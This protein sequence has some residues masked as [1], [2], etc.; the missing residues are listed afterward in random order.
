MC[1]TPKLWGK[2]DCPVSMPKD[3]VIRDL[4]MKGTGIFILRFPNTKLQ[5]EATDICI[6]VQPIWGKGKVC[7]ILFYVNRSNRQICV[8]IPHY[9]FTVP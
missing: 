2:P 7:N 5:L 9:D 8:Q 4:K 3:P 1:V 6:E